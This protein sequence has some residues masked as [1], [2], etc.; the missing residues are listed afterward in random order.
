[1]GGDDR[2]GEDHVGEDSKSWRV[3]IESTLS[4]CVPGKAKSR[5]DW[6]LVR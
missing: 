5:I 1:M 3:L 2:A 6:G 4:A